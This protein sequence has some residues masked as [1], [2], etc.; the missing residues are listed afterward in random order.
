[1]EGGKE[2]AEKDKDPVSCVETLCDLQP[3]GGDLGVLG[4]GALQPASQ[5]FGCGSPADGIYSRGD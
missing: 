3:Q 5:P 4:V 1:M 2:K